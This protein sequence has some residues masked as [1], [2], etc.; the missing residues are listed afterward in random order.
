MR[1]SSVGNTQAVT[2]EAGVERHG[3]WRSCWLYPV[4]GPATRPDNRFARGSRPNVRH[5]HRPSSGVKLIV[6]ATLRPLTA[7]LKRGDSAVTTRLGVLRNLF[8]IQ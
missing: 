8:K 7:N 2:F 3:P 1:S 6:V 4:Q 5:C